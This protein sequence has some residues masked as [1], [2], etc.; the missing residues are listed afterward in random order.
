MFLLVFLDDATTQ[1]KD[2]ITEQDRSSC[3]DG[4]LDIYDLRDGN[5]VWRYLDGQWENVEPS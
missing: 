5:S 4:H 3:D 1:L 2:T